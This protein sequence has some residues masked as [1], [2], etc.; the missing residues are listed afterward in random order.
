[1]TRPPK[2]RGAIPRRLT[3]GI[4]RRDALADAGNFMP[5]ALFIAA[6]T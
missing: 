4:G 5:F 6:L 3:R 2:K 1:L